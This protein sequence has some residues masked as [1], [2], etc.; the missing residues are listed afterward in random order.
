LRFYESRASNYVPVLL[1]MLADPSPTVRPSAALAL[2]LVSPQYAETAVAVM[3]DQQRTNDSWTGDNAHLLY[4]AMGPAA[5]LAVPTLRVEL[6]DA[7][8]VIFHGDAAG[9][10]WRITGEVTSQI[11]EGLS[12]GV[13]I[14][15]QRTQLRCLH[16]LREI[17]PPATAA[18]PAL[19]SLTNHPRILIRQLACE[20][21]ESISRPLAK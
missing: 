2:G 17:G 10:L 8:R 14:G 6:T 19:H 3:L 15:V 5:N 21:L 20:A 9:A 18:A 13:R 4:Q 7:R 12:T 16:I 11:V 1:Q